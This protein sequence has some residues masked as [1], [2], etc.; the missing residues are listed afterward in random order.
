MK[1]L[2]SFLFLGLLF[3]SASAFSQDAKDKEVMDAAKKAKQNLEKTD[4]GLKKFFNNSSGYVIFPSVGEGA[5]IIGGAGGNGVVYERGSAVGMATLAKIDIGAQAG[6]QSLTEVIF[7]ET[8]EALNDFKQG[9]Y[10]MS[11]EISAIA[12]KSGASANANYNDGVVVFTKPKE[13]LMADA[14]V[15]GQKFTYKAF[16]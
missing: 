9:N 12:V 5:L 15:G 3:I 10:E 1:T 2:K 16:K 4:P 8:K 11:A 14:S 6:G 7:F 13:G